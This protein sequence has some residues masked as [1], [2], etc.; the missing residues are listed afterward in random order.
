MGGRLDGKIAIV[1]GGA[2]GIGSATGR[3]FCAEGARVVL[4]D[5]DPGAMKSAVEEI[6]E[7]VPGAELR[8]LIID[9]GKEASAAEIITETRRTFGQVDVLV[10]NAGIRSYEPLAEANR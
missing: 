9:V 3:L 10:N 1:T 8:D 2:G 4:V 6:R 5:W 7:A